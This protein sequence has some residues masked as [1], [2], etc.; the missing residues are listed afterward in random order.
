MLTAGGL[1]LVPR[2]PGTWG[3]LGGLLQF[4]AL[5]HAGA[6]WAVPLCG[7]AWLGASWALAGVAL[8]RWGGRDPQAVV[9]D[10]VGGYL[11]A[12]SLTGWSGLGWWWRAGLGLVLFRLFDVAKPG[13]VRRAEGLPAGLGIAADDLVAGLLANACLQ[14]VG[15]ALL[16]RA[17]S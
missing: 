10:E 6:E 13:P 4:A 16:P 3:T 12:V 7:L 5:A 17:P 9:S 15:L 11:L 1:G 2:A 14:L 8:R